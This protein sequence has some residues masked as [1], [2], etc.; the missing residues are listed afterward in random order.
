MEEL[1]KGLEQ[2]LQQRGHYLL[3]NDPLAQKILGKMEGIKEALSSMNGHTKE[4]V[5]TEAGE[6]EVTE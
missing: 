1:L 6:V 3:N 4:E 2:Q 5:L